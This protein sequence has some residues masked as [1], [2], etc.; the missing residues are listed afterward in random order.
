[1]SSKEL[2]P[3]GEWCKKVAIESAKASYQIGEGLLILAL[4]LISPAIY[5]CG[6]IYFRA[7]EGRSNCLVW[8]VSQRLKHAWRCR[9]WSSA[10]VICVRNA[11]GRRHWQVLVPDT[12]NVYEWYAKGASKRSRL[13]NL[14]YRGEL[15][16]VG[17]L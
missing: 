13:A 2:M 17:K 5:A 3:F 14:W 7:L 11:R 8:A 10:R 12:G 4:V 6:V 9:R 1:M 16:K 15:K